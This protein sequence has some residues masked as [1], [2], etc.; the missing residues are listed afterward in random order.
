MFKLLSINVMAISLV[1]CGGETVSQ[2]SNP[3][4]Q[5]IG[6]QMPAQGLVLEP[7]DPFAPVLGQK[8]GGHD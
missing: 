2:P 6:Q 4:Q 1:A 8:N 5:A 7:K 3:F